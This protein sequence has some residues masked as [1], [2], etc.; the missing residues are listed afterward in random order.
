MNLAL[1]NSYNNK[2]VKSN[3]INGLMTYIKMNLKDSK[4]KM[5][6]LDKFFLNR[7]KQKE[8]NK[9]INE[10]NPINN[11]NINLIENEIN[12]SNPKE[13]N[14]NA[15]NSYRNNFNK[16]EKKDI[17]RK[18]K[19]QTINYNQYK[20]L[21]NSTNIKQDFKCKFCLKTFNFQEFKEHYNLC[22]KNQ[23]NINSMNNSNV[24]D[25]NS[26]EKSG[27]NI[28][29][30]SNS[31]TVFTS[32]KI[33]NSHLDNDIN[34]DNIYINKIPI[35]K[36]TLSNSSI[37]TNNNSNLRGSNAKNMNNNNGNS[38]NNS[39]RVSLTNNQTLNKRPK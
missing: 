13:N 21:I 25:N 16:Y 35:K 34:N 4:D 8:E 6:K 17:N 2:L 9:E 37:N 5:L 15:N 38:N 1:N 24:Y 29:M 14:S 20:D 3:N 27:H 36:F 10:Q 30:N 28:K 22:P 33:S 19:E 31:N 39:N 18:I 12:D 32:D 11:E 23:M 26:K 7:K